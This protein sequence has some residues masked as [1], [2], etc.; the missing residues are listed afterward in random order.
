MSDVLTIKHGANFRGG[1]SF[2]GMFVFLAGVLLLIYN[3]NINT[4][5]GIIGAIG[6][7]GMIALGANMF[8][9]FEG[10]QFD[11]RSQKVREYYS[12]MG[13]RLG[14]WHSM[15]D[16]EQ[17]VLTIDRFSVPTSTPFTPRRSTVKHTFDVMLVRPN[18][19]QGMMLV[20][21]KTYQQGKAKLEE[22]SAK[23]NLPAYNQCLNELEQSKARRMTRG[24]RR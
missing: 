23:L 1:I 2:F 11:M 18:Q 3:F 14:V 24:R 19:K 4:L 16:Y 12:L 13:F 5:N 20:E 17:V 22:L 9:G 15:T 8:L 6:N 10:V 7:A 21:C